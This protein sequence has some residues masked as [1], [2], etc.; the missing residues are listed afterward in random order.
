MSYPE[1]IKQ[2]NWKV[3]QLD[4]IDIRPDSL[5]AFK[6][7]YLRTKLTSAPDIIIT[8]PPF[9][10]AMEFIQKALWDVKPG[11]IVIKLLRLNFFGSRKRRAWFQS[12][13]PVYTYVHAERL[14]FWPE[15]PSQA[16]LDWW[17]SL[18]KGAPPNASSTDSIEYMHCVWIQGQHPRF[19]QLRVI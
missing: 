4:T 16:M 10:V 2:A 1:A 3:G 18:D 9:C 6:G 8:N 17:A 13:M 7:D 15:H 11:G 14:G 5:A 12:N 19:T